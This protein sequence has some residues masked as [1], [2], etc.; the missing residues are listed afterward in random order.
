M[1]SNQNV[2]ITINIHE[3]GDKKISLTQKKQR[4]T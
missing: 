4:E 3:P 1:K 2:N